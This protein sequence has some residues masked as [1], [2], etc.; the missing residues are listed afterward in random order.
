MLGLLAAGRAAPQIAGELHVEVSTVRSHVKSI[1]AKPGATGR[2]DAL[3]RAR[4]AGLID[5]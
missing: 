5:P 1:Y 4:A 2:V 3:L